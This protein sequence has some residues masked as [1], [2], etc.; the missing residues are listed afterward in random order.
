MKDEIE[1]IKD[2]VIYCLDN[3]P[4]TR[5]CD[6]KLIFKVLLETGF[7]FRIEK[8]IG[9]SYEKIQEMPSF[10]SIRRTRQKLQELGEFLPTEKV[11]EFREQNKQEMH[12]INTW[13]SSDIGMKDSS[14]T[15]LVEEYSD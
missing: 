6:K 13:W 12:E 10:E 5:S 1:S 4:E 7:A 2:V 14:Q 11:Q 3:F 8:G 9:F 15:L